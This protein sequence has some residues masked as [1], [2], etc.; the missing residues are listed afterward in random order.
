MQ[1]FQNMSITGFV[2]LI[3][4]FLTLIPE[5]YFSGILVMIISAGLHIKQFDELR[6][7]E[8]EQTNWSAPQEH[9]SGL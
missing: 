6:L 1:R 2:L 8:Q 5:I 9:Y 3:L 4:G 7:S